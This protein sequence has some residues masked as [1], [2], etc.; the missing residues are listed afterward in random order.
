MPDLNAYAVLPMPECPAE[1]FD[2]PVTLAR[3][4][5]Q[6]VTRWPGGSGS[7]AVL[8][9]SMITEDGFPSS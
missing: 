3:A 2:N 4:V 5:C 8:G 7:A 9:S 6:T 1:W